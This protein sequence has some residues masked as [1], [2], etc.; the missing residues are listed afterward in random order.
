M[1][2]EYGQNDLFK[3]NLEFLAKLCKKNDITKSFFVQIPYI[4]TST[5]IYEYIVSISPFVYRWY[6]IFPPKKSGRI[7]QI[8]TNLC[9]GVQ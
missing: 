1:D 2:V 5:F 6:A 3:L 7:T 4:C 9:S 8:S